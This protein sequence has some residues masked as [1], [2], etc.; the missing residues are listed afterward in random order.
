MNHTA[1]IWTFEKISAARSRSARRPAPFFTALC[2][3]SL[4]GFAQGLPPV[5]YPAENPHSEE[6]R[7][8]GKLLFWDEQLSSNDTIACGTCHIPSFGGTDPR[9]GLNPGFDGLFATEDDVIGS[10]GVIRMDA[11][12]NPI[13][14]PLFGF[15]TQV[16]GRA[17]Q[18]YFVSMF[19]RE[20]F[21][22]GRASPRFLDP[23]DGI[24][25]LIADFG[26]LE[27]QAV[28]PIV[29]SVEMAHQGRSW[30]DV[31]AK[32]GNVR[33]LLMASDIPADM[34]GAIGESPTYP[35]LF[36]KAFGDS[37]I[38]A[39]RIAFAIATYERT[40]SSDQTPWDR[41]EDGDSTAMTPAQI[42]GWES[43]RDRTV[44]LNCHPPPLFTDNQFHNIGLR[45]SFEDEGRYEV[46]GDERDHGRF[47]TPTLRN[48][49]LKS[50]MMHVGWIVDV[51]DA[52]NFY[53]AGTQIT[54]HEQFTEDQSGIPTN[55]PGV[56]AD[57]NTLDMDPRMQPDII[58]FIVNG[59]TD[60]R[61]ANEQFPFDRPTLKSEMINAPVIFSSGTYVGFENGGEAMPYN[62]LEEALIHVAEDGSIV[63]SPGTISG[64]IRIEQPVTLECPS[65][66][67]T[68]GVE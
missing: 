48:I 55:T 57:Y 12:R 49:G 22:D 54:G 25:E 9:L 11:N 39:G 36:S 26:G 66:T 18:S 3:V 38:N 27:S 42:N 37:E 6:K 32:L 67:A 68:I 5:R 7:V 51:Q 60:P 34:Q 65:G 14:D 8:L 64:A 31:K 20:N 41:Y 35:E 56:F 29:S 1:R 59:L 50:S 53:N 61:V 13:E 30:D 19:A 16:T 46:M 2:L 15:A 47:K 44:C 43:L 17:A 23:E 62:T 40:L 21:W 63:I 24:T 33:P 58:D 10:P 52:I 28:G 4:H 45:P